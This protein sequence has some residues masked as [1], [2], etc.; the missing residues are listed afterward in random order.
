METGLEN[1]ELWKIREIPP[2][3]PW[4]TCGAYQSGVLGVGV[5]GISYAVFIGSLVHDAH[6]CYVKYQNRKWVK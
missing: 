5:G 3:I 2:F 6:L 1:L 4:N